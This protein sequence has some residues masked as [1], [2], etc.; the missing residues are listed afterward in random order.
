MIARRGMDWQFAVCLTAA[1]IRL[2]RG[3]AGNVPHSK[4]L[5]P[6]DGFRCYAV[7]SNCDHCRAN[8][9][10]IFRKNRAIPSRMSAVF[11]RAIGQ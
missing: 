11:T 9:R 1:A 6:G 5:A 7:E 8:L 10:M 3:N 4:S 2:A